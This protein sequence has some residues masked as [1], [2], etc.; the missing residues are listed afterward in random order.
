MVA[1]TRAQY[2]AREWEERFTSLGAR[3]LLCSTIQ[4]TPPDDWSEFDKGLKRWD[5]I[6][7]I[8]FTSA[9][10]VTFSLTALL[11]WDSR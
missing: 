8:I 3:V 7:W 2:Q 10:S 4:I 11:K 1:I 9:N 6:E 5:D